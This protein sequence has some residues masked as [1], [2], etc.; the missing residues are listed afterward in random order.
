MLLLG[1]LSNIYHIKYIYRQSSH[2]FSIIIEI[3]KKK[4]KKKRK[5]KK[6]KKEKKKEKRKKK[7]V[8]HLIKIDGSGSER[9]RTAIFRCGPRKNAWE[10]TQ[11]QKA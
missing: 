9:K 3:K 6:K 1:H 2:L 5:R 11:N 4:E 10:K 7:K 8:A